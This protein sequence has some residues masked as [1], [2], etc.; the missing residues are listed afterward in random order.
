[1]VRVGG[2]ARVGGGV[3]ISL[4][5]GQRLRQMETRSVIGRWF[6]LLGHALGAWS[7]VGDVAG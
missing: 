5:R 2:V 6:G 7:V 1:M 4:G 3:V